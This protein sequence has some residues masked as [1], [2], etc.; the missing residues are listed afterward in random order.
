MVHSRKRFTDRNGRITARAIRARSALQVKIRKGP[1]GTRIRLAGQGEAVRGREERRSLLRVVC[2]APGFHVEEATDMRQRRVAGC[3][4]GELQGRLWRERASENSASTRGRFSFG[5]HGL[6]RAAGGR[7][8]VVVTQIEIPKKM[9]ERE[10]EVWKQLAGLKGLAERFARPVRAPR[11]RKTTEKISL[12]TDNAGFPHKEKGRR[13]WDRSDRV[14]FGTLAR[15]VDY[16][17]LSPAANSAKGECDGHV[18]AVRGW[19]AMAQQSARCRARFA[20]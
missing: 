19:R 8:I 1:E 4:G 20:G 12:G 9:K 17:F 10:R 7:A 13:C 18:S 14:G 3:D 6:P 2:A 5:G 15:T 16:R 11:I